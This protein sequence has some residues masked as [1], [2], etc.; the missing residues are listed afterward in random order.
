MR[1]IIGVPTL[2]RGIETR[3]IYDSFGISPQLLSLWIKRKI[4][5]PSIRRG[6]RGFTHLWSFY[7]VLDLKTII[8]LRRRGLSMQKIRKVLAWLRTHGHALHS[9]N[10]ATD[11]K[12]VWVDLDDVTLEII[13]ATCGQ[14]VC[15][16]WR[17]IVSYCQK[18]LADRGIDRR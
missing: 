13:E 14:I 15:L 5:A 7:D 2:N 17:D 12:S 11:G 10:L 1:P 8:G 9:T 6:H 3:V 4:I 18:L 16:D